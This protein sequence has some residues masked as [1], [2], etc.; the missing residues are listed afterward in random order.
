MSGDP[1]LVT[2]RHGSDQIGALGQDLDEVI[3]TLVTTRENLEAVLGSVDVGLVTSDAD[4]HLTLANARARDLL[5]EADAEL[6]G[7]SLADIFASEEP[8][9]SF[10]RSAEKAHAPMSAEVPWAGGLSVGGRV[11]AASASRLVQD[12]ATEGLVLSLLDV[13]ELRLAERRARENERLAALGGMAGGLLHELG[14]PLAGLTIYLDL[15][16]SS[17]PEGEAQDILH[18]AIRE[19]TRLQEFLEDFRVFA[20]L[21]TLRRGAVDLRSLAERAQEPLAWPPDIERSVDASGCA[22][23]DARL[24]A[25]ALRNLL[26]NAQEALPGGGRVCVDLT[27]GN[28]EAVA[29][30]TDD[31]DGLTSA[32]IDRVLEPFHTTKPHG[33][34]LGL[35]IARRV[36][37]L[38]GGRLEARSRPGRGAEFT[39]RW[40]AMPVNR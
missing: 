13:T 22:D 4:G 35:L 31:G 9:L 5:G 29:T 14:N 20:G 39:L 10:I 18:R 40:P 24:L 3:A 36:A 21:A 32:Q 30:V 27:C 28:G 26:R 19:G 37:E 12:G 17:A 7:R 2:Q 1:R 6:V 16:R 23:G 11:L 38:H 8:L 34:G 25:H 15:L 33:S